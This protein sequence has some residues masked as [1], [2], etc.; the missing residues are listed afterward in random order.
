MT[1]HTPPRWALATILACVLA[2]TAA[3]AQWSD[4]LYL[5]AGGLYVL[6]AELSYTHD[7]EMETVKG[8]VE[9]ES[10]MGFLIAMGA[11]DVGLRGELE[12]GYRKMDLGE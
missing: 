8:D 4:S 2:P 11:G 7:D 10:G 12:L 5:S 3:A 6:P 9:L 1:H